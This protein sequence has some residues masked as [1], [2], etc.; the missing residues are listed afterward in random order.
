VTDKLVARLDGRSF[1][2]QHL[3]LRTYPSTSNRI[4]TRN[5]SVGSVCLFFT[6]LSDMECLTAPVNPVF[7]SV[8]LLLISEWLIRQSGTVYY[9]FSALYQSFCHIKTICSE[10]SL[11]PIASSIEW[12]NENTSNMNRC[13]SF[14]ELI[15]F[16]MLCYFIIALIISYT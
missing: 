5:K 11:T 7:S 12:L 9:F 10:W 6:N 1:S 3:D 4:H 16:G 13:R 15:A 8:N 14:I 2:T